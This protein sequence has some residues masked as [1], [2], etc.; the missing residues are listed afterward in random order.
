MSEITLTGLLMLFVAG[1]LVY[2]FR[3]RPR[4]ADIS[5]LAELRAR[6]PQT[7]FTIVQFYAPL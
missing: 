7:R 1:Y 4:P 2:H 5:S 3:G 6:I